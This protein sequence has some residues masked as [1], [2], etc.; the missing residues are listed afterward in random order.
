MQ[1]ISSWLLHA[2]PSRSLSIPP[3]P[4]L[5]RF[6]YRSPRRRRRALATADPDA[7]C[8][9]GCRGLVVEPN[10][11]TEHAVSGLDA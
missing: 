4:P 9:T 3:A 2:N 7:I 6:R 11:R 10:V 1:I 8:G 5:P